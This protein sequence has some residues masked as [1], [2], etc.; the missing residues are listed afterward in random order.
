MYL[1]RYVNV[2]NLRGKKNVLRYLIF[3]IFF[4]SLKM[5]VLNFDYL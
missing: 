3:C 5:G 4:F 2:I 1:V